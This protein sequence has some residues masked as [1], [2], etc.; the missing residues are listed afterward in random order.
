[1][2]AYRDFAPK[3]TTV[4]RGSSYFSWP[5]QVYESFDEAVL[6]A[7]AW[8]AEDQI[9]VRQIETVVLPN[10]WS[11][12]EEGSADPALQAR[13]GTVWHQFVRVWYDK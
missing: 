13:P 4:D 8:I 6:A 11:P 1:M 7:D 2:L 12:Q 5:V 10:I 3:V 9:Q